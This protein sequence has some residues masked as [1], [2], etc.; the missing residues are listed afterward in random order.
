MLTTIGFA[1]VIDEKHVLRKNGSSI[2]ANRVVGTYR[3]RRITT[4]FTF[5]NVLYDF[6]KDFCFSFF[7]QMPF[8]KHSYLSNVRCSTNENVQIN[9]ISIKK[10]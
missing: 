5:A 2:G 1:T 7:A 10:L 6:E 4:R 8:G 3:V 9:S